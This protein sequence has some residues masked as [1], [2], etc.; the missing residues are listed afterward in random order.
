[1]GTPLACSY[2]SRI[3]TIYAESVSLVLNSE[4]G[5]VSTQFHVVFDDEFFTVPFM[6]E[7][8]I[9]PNL[10]DLV[11]HSSQISAPDNI[12]LTDT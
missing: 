6:R 5:H 7:G 3:I 8:I 12:D 1:M 11:Q 4:T 9:P 2:L 10:T